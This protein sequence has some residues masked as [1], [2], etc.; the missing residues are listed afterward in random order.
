MDNNNPDNNLGELCDQVFSHSPG[1]ECS[2]RLYLDETIACDVAAKEHAVYIFEILVQVLF[3]GIK[4][5]FGTNDSGLIVLSD[6]TH[7][8]FATLRQYFRMMEY[9]ILL[10][11][12]PENS[13]PNYPPFDAEDFTTLHLKFIKT[14]DTGDKEYVD[15]H[16]AAYTLPD[17]PIRV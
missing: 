7:Q 14:L 1:A 3:G 11:I 15:I 5:L 13:P 9:D 2:M 6:L 8:N 4:I 17:V 10:D 12:Y 16:F